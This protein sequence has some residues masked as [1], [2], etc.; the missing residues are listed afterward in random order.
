MKFLRTG[1]FRIKLYKLISLVYADLSFIPTETSQH[2]FDNFPV[3]L[4]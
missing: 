2:L 4:H 1:S 3:F